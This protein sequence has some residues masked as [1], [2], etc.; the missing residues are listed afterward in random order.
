M[1]GELESLTLRYLR[2]IDEKLD[3]LIDRVDDLTTRVNTL[4]RTVARRR[5]VLG[6]EG[7]EIAGI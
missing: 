7:V 4:E 3:R 5:V 1:S 2:R 6:G